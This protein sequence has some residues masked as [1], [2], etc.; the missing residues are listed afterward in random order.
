MKKILIAGYESQT[1]NYCSA[2]SAFGAAVFPLSSSPEQLVSETFQDIHS[3]ACLYDGLVLPGGGDISPSLFHR[4][5]R[6]SRNI[7][8]ALDR[9]QLCLLHAFIQA[10]KPVL[11][12]CKGLQ[13]I[14]V[15]FGGTILQ[16]LNPSS[17]AIH[18]WENRDKVHPAKTARGTFLYPLYGPMP[19]VNSAHHQAL[20]AVGGGLRVAAYARDF[21]VEA[22][23]HENLPVF[24]VQWH[25]ERMCLSFARKDMADGSL[26]LK[27][28]ISL[29]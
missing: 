25:P 22:L 18:S 12:I 20:G 26:L 19:A 6:G 28:F 14:N 5:N 15:G 7:D 10:G 1:V 29:L 24:G 16:D 8:E 4:E 13:I 23:Y 3:C 11:G 21:V 2:F 27:Y 17:L 9:V